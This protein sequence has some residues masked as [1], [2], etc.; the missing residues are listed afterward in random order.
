MVPSQ[1]ILQINIS[2]KFS[3]V[4]I[5]SAIS[6]GM[7]SWLPDGYSQIFR[8]YVFGHSGLKDYGSDTLRCKI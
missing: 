4:Q 6:I 5:I 2:P 3:S 8:L 1:L 7:E